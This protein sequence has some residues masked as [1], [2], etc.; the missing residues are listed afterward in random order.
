[1]FLLL[2]FRFAF[3]MVDIQVVK[4]LISKKQLD[5]EFYL[6]TKSMTSIDSNCPQF[7]NELPTCM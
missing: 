6:T 2:Y 1:M 3:I 7:S 4:R 5:E